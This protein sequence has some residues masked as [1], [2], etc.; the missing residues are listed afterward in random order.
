VSIRHSEE[1]VGL[2]GWW[3]ASYLVLWLLVLVLCL[4]VVALARQIGTL[5]LRVESRGALEVDD[6]GP[7]LEEA[8]PPTETVD[9]RG[10][11]VVLGGPGEAQMLL[12]VSPGCR[13]C[14]EVL[15]AVGPV[16]Q[17]GRLVPYIVTDVDREKT[18][19]AFGDR[20]GAPVVPGP[21]IAAAFGVPGTPYAVILDRTGAA[22]AKG[23]VN[24]LEQ[25]EGLV[26]TAARRLGAGRNHP[27]GSA[28][29]A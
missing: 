4:V 22:V 18:L 11:P 16:A 2:E 8:I 15:P 27:S 26:D 25:M 10:R 28:V 17:T 6:E 21:E 29:D 12:F 5:L 23:T 19:S 20:L 24:T 3:A 1:G 13:L 7:P 9:A 14:R